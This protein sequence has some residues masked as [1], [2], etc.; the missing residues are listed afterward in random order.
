[1]CDD[2]NPLFCHKKPQQTQG[3]RA[4]VD[5]NGIAIRDLLGGQTADE[6]LVDLVETRTDGRRHGT[7]RHRSGYA[8][9]YL[10]DVTALLKLVQVAA[11][12]IL[13]HAKNLAQLV[14]A[15]GLARD[16]ILLYRIE[17]AD[18]HIHSSHIIISA[19]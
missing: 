14:N 2:C 10:G 6:R 19:Q 4:G 16:D 5:K 13:G 3:G 8:A 1:M 18:F 12:G 9:V 11:D 15:D 7:G 17:T